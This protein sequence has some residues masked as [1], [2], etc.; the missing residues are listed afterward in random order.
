MIT[1]DAKLVMQMK[2][3]LLVQSYI[4]TVTSVVLIFNKSVYVT[5]R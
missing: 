2:F 1:R 5:G 3:E 4:K